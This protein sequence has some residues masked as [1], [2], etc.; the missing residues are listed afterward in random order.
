MAPRETESTEYGVS[1]CGGSDRDRGLRQ[2]CRSGQAVWNN[3]LIG[4]ARVAEF[5][6]GAEQPRTREQHSTRMLEQREHICWSS[7][8]GRFEV[9]LSDVYCYHRA[10]CTPIHHAEAI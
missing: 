4:P 6:R 2:W 1:A 5:A 9:L 8:A 7:R 3:G 10:E